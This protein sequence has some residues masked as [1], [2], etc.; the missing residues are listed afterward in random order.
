M[1]VVKTYYALAKPG[2]IYGNILVAAG[3]YLLAAQRHVHIGT[4]VLMLLGLSLIIGSACVFNNYLDRDID[5]LMKR[6]KKRAL[7]TGLISPLSSIIYATVIG[8]L[9]VSILAVFT[10]WLTVSIAL[11]GHFFY[12]VV[13]GFAKRRSVHGTLVGSISGALPPLVG[14]CAATNRLD[15]GALL[16]FVLLVAWQMPHFY[17]IALYRKNEYSAANIPVLPVVKGEQEAKR[18]IFFYIIAYL[19]CAILL[20]LFGYTGYPYLVITIGIG[21]AWLRLGLQGFKQAESEIWARK[22]FRFSLIV[23][24]AW[25]FVI[26]LDALLH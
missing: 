20:T 15:L 17:A 4:L 23:I 21:L 25:C 22:T 13:Y 24:T 2:I 6:T 5:V 9:G 18:Q 14:Y 19:L 16:L 11:I 7:V 10:N 12:V 1:N 26:P 8:L 3:G